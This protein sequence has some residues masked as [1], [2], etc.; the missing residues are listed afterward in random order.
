MAII[1]KRRSLHKLR[2]CFYLRSENPYGMKRKKE[3]HME[4]LKLVLPTLDMEKEALSYRQ[5]YI[6]YGE[7]YIHGSAGLMKEEDYKLWVEKIT[8][9]R[10]EKMPE[11]LV[12]ASTYFAV[13]G[14]RIVGTIQIRYRLNEFLLNYGGHIGY[15]VRPSERRKG[16]AT[17]MLSQALEICRNLGLECV[18]ITCDKDN[19]GSARTVMKNGGILENEIPREDGG[20]TQRYWITLK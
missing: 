9:A 7:T 6:D 2:F 10:T 12:N 5:E 1:N 20:I 13:V 17:E 15:G 16:Y 14:D 4:N 3:W 19:I 8:Y 18:L 11:G